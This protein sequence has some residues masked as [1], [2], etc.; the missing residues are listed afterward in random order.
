MGRAETSSTN[1]SLGHVERLL[2]LF[3]LDDEIGSLAKKR[4]QLERGALREGKREDEN[5]WEG[6]PRFLFT[7]LSKQ[8]SVTEV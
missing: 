1:L 6:S 4:G 2:Q 5:C 3:G 7:P 8:T